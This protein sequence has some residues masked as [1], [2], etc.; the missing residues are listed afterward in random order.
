MQNDRLEPSKP[1]GTDGA[2]QNPESS[3]Y[4]SRSL[5]NL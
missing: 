5:V 3:K 4:C 1:T 2:E